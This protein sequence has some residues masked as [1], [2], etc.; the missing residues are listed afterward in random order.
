VV[1][2]QL[3]HPPLYLNPS[4]LTAL[5]AAAPLGLAYVAAALR[6]AGHD[7]SLL[8]AVAEAPRQQTREGRVMRLGLTDE[9]IAARIDPEAQAI[10]VTNMWSFS[11]PAVRSMLQAIRRRRPDVI[12]VCGGEHF[13]GLPAY[14]MAQAPIDYIVLGEGEEIAVELFAALGGS[15]PFDPAAIAGLCWRRGSEVVENPRASRTR[16]V[17]DLAWP[18]WDLFDLDVYDDNNFVGGVKYGR[19][20]PVLATRGCP[21]QCTYCSSPQMWTTRWYARDPIDVADEIEFYTKQ[22]RATNFPFQDLTAI[23]RREWVVDFCREIIRRGLRITWQMPTGTR[24]EVVDEEVAELLARSGGYTLAFAPESG[25]ERTRRLIK[26][27]MRTDRLLDAV[28][29]SVKAKLN[30]SALLVIGFPHDLD[31]DLRETVRLVRRLGRMGV[32]D[33]ACAF[34]FPI[35]ST[36]L[37]DQLIESGRISLTDEFLMT[38]I[39]VHDRSLSEDRNYCTQLSARRLTAYKYWIVANF[40]LTAWATHPSRPLRHVYNALTG[41][42][43]S[44]MD[45]FLNET[46]RRVAGALGLRRHRPGSAGAPLR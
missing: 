41:R 38:P 30:L 22:Y 4:A 21:Y 26:K 42:E 33:V 9:Q 6:R 11:W 8:D 40:Y 20:V 1:R 46:R 12:I 27:K 14:S 18:A 16:A 10:G 19:T 28:R 44:K 23:I 35:P 29:A 5:R 24:C 32:D 13:T 3:L 7:V 37:Y 31:E 17:D 34:F 15:G 45:T 39:F 36:E 43:R 25:S 2:V